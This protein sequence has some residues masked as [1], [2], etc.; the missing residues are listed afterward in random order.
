MF[1]CCSIKEE[2]DLVMEEDVILTKEASLA[3]KSYGRISFKEQGSVIASKL[4]KFDKE[5][6]TGVVESLSAERIEGI[7][8]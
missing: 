3:Q 1:E 4:L 7:K 6:R 5:G 2:P 8:G